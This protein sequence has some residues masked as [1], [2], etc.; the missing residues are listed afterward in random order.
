MREQAALANETTPVPSGVAHDAAT[1]A[2]IPV[3]DETALIARLERLV[4]HDAS[5]SRRAFDGDHDRVVAALAA[6]RQSIGAGRLEAGAAALR[7]CL[8]LKPDH[9][10]CHK[11]A[12]LVA[13][14]MGR[15]GQARQHYERYLSLV[16]GAPDTRW[17]R[18][19]LGEL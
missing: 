17:V 1:E 19:Y 16:A 3:S 10:Q 8:R 7:R 14:F 11:L 18:A 15:K 2:L 13:Q 6:A 9:P 12:G 4:A 5:P